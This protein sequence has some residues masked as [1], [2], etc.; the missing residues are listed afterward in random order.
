MS[1]SDAHRT[2]FTVRC[3]CGIEYHTSDAH[4]GHALPC[5]CGRTVVITRAP[6]DAAPDNARPKRKKRRFEATDSETERAAKLLSGFRRRG[7]LVSAFLYP[8]RFGGWIARATFMGSIAYLAGMFVAWMLLRFGSERI[9]PGTIIA[10]GPRFL[11]LVPL[12]LLLPA[13]LLVARSALLPLAIA[14]W[15]GLVPVMGARVNLSTLRSEPPPAPVDGTFRVMTFNVQGGGGL[16]RGFRPMLYDL[17]PDVVL[18][19][20]CSERLWRIIRRQND[21]HSAQH[22]Q[23][24]LM[25]RWPLKLVE[26]MPREAI[27]SM[28]SG[29]GGGS[30]FVMR[31]YIDSPRGQLI[32]IN[33]HLETARRGLEGMLS[34]EGLIPDD[35]L[36]VSP[37]TVREPIVS[38]TE[39]IARFAANVAVRD[40][41]SALASAW[42]REAS[43]QGALVVG[44]DFNLP[45]ESNIFRTHWGDF[46]DAFEAKGNGLGWTKR[47]GRWLRIRIDH[48]LTTKDG[49]QPLNVMV[50][51]NY[52]SDHRPVIADYAWSTSVP[53]PPPR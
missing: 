29:G 9:I 20:E 33:L 14:A 39:N 28:S 36:D 27:L 6:E 2:E 46:V 22:G 49:P 8:W 18:M 10:F 52:G 26:T 7:G 47:E 19:Q 15:I 35:P 48:L 13:A 30:G 4:L 17:A 32:V 1:K 12:V 21:W 45:V 51:P 38:T 40:K 25:S 5:K 23:T 34:P 42:A 43:K 24:C 11:S 3:A 53:S 16:R 31:A 44:G 50:G 41:E 37:D